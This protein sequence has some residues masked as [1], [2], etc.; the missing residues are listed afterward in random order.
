MQWIE[1]FLTG[2]KQRV[3]VNGGKSTWAEVLSGIP[4]GSVLGPI[5]FLIFIDDLP[6][7]V[8]GLVKIFA[9]DTKVFSAI[10]EEED[11]KSLQKDL[12]HLSEWSDKWQL[13]FNVS[14]CGVMYYGNRSE[15][16]AYS[17]EEGG[18]KRE[19]AKLNEEKDLGVIFDPSMTFSKHVGMIANKAN[20]ILGVIKRTSSFMDIDMFTI[21]Y[22]TLVRVRPHLEYAN[23]IWNP[24][25][26]KDIQLIESVQRRATKLVPQLKD[27]PYA[28]RLRRLKL[29]TLAYRRITWH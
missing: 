24:I 18:V 3:I 17:M 27:L 13:R 21:L 2:R 9:D 4:Q 15:K 14:K 16:H 6:D 20:R 12:D 26:Q 25:L 23:C 5:L 28:D 11:Y 29:P 1:S 22:K 8:E 10:N 7:S 19:L